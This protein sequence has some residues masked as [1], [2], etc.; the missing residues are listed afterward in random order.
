MRRLLIVLPR[1]LAW[2]LVLVGFV[3]PVGSLVLRS[4]QAREVVTVEGEVFRAVGEVSV[5]DEDVS[6]SLQSAP[7]E[8]K[9][10]WSIDRSELAEVRTVWSLD[11]Y[12]HL[13]DDART[14]GLLRNSA[15][16]ALGGAL[17]ALLLGLPMA[18][19]LFRT[20]LRGR[21]LLAV[22]CLAPAILPPFFIALG[23]A[24][25]MQD[26]LI[27]VF[28]VQGGTLQILNSI[29]VFGCVL[30]PLYVL[31]VGRALAAVPAGP[32][33]AAR[34][35]G[36]PRAALRHV[37]VPAVLPSIVGS[38]VLALL[39]ALTDFAVPDVLG[40]MLPAGGTPSHVF[41][42]EVLLQWKQ[43]G[44]TGRA[45][46]TAAP[47]ICATVLLLG[48]A[49]LLLRRSPAFTSARGER[50]RAPVA[51]RL[52]GYLLAWLY[53]ACL[54][55]LSLVLP[56]QGIASWAGEGGESASAGTSANTAAATDVGSRLFDFEG[57]L[58]RTVGSREERDRWLHSALA[59][60]LLAMCIA[61][62]LARTATRGGPVARALVLAVGVIPLAVPGLVLSVGTLLFWQALPLFVDQGLR[63]LESILGFDPRS[64]LVLSAKFLPFA[65]LTAW[66][67]FRQVRRGHEDAAAMVGAGPGVRAWRIVWPAT[68]VGVFSG[69]LL[70]L[71][72]A[73]R[74]LD[75]IMLVDAR[76][77]PMRLYD[78]IHFNRMADEANLLFLCLAYLLVPALLCALVLGLRSRFRDL[79]RG[80]PRA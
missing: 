13:F 50:R 37:V 73:L 27:S 38:F 9:Q 12:R 34:I 64:A 80:G 1:I 53:I 79:R 25:P 33:E 56:L 30:F 54:L 71:V 70:V 52:R 22:L 76:V 16:I 36:G 39:L 5:G 43:Q 69:G 31:L 47:F 60:A 61:A 26:A 44:N 77:L 28:H 57:T 72:L 6:F 7:G 14:Q 51:L 68:W 75:T 66:L 58:D 10:P 42:T 55:G 46:A 35:L 11:H 17:L 20:R 4:F 48:V 49:L 59:A 65:L 19:I 23:S 63:S 3:L 67:A 21:S 41:A 40:F 74:E 15:W 62:P 8:E 24:R 32:Y 78:K 2:T 18:W 29:L 45:V